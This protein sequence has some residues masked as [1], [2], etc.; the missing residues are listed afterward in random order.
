MVVEEEAG[1]AKEPVITTNLHM[2]AAVE[3]E[4]G[5]GESCSTRPIVM[6]F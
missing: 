5:L 1:K 6:V 4:L 2:I 3:E